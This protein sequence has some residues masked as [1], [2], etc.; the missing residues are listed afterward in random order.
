MAY[1]RLVCF[2]TDH[3]KRLEKPLALPQHHNHSSRLR[4][5]SERGA[6]RPRTVL[7]LGG[8]GMRGMAHVGVLKALRTLGIQFDAIIGTSIGSLVGTMA[9]AGMSIEEMERTITSVQKGDYF[10]LNVVKFLLKG[11]RAPSMYSGE[12]FRA[13]LAEI[14][15][16]GSFDCLSLPFFCNSVRLETGGS[17]F[18]GTPGFDDVSLVDAVY[19]SCA[20]PGIFEPYQ[21]DGYNYMDG[22]IVDS[23]PLRFA[24]TLAPDLIIAVDLTVKA[25]F[26]TPNYK[27]RVVGTLYR[28]F[29][30]AE[31]VIVENQL[32]MHADSKVALIQPKVGHLSRFDFNEVREVI[33]LGEEEALRVLTS[34]ASTRNL[35]Q[36][37]VIPGLSCPVTPRDYVTLDVDPE[38]CVGCGLCEMVCET[39][40]FWAQGEQ[41]TV[42]KLTNYECTR[43]HACSRNCPTN[44]IRLGNL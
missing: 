33:T 21:R 6:R 30:I 10:K 3:N 9:A 28:A 15:P 16:S 11:V 25:T 38:L 44:A 23:V 40:G 29:E 18:W 13:R 41:A 43:D 20:L 24:K 32:H 31:E 5:P 7:V 27:R 37:V 4:L 8:G 12:T 19:S 2:T 17:V 22:G 26:K 36:P 14:L 34:H 1:Q 39:D 42:R 35:V